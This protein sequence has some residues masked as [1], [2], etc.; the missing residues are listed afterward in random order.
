MLDN[1][2]DYSKFNGFILLYILMEATDRNSHS[3]IL[4][5]RFFPHKNK[6]QNVYHIN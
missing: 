1:L 6:Q 2:V 3:S 4:L 5:D